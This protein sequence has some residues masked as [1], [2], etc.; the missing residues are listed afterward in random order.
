MD[1]R[2]AMVKQPLA[3]VNNIHMLSDDIHMLLSN[4]LLGVCDC[5]MSHETGHLLRLLFGP[6][7]GEWETKY[8]Q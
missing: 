3:T 5:P 8:V 7:A 2:P 1:I 4:L 6:G